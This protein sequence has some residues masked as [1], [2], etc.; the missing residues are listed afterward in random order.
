M[1]DQ[2]RDSKDS[3]PRQIVWTTV[4]CDGKIPNLEV[5]ALPDGLGVFCAVD[6]HLVHV[7]DAD[8]ADGQITRHQDSAALREQKVA[9]ATKANAETPKKSARD[10]AKSVRDIEKAHFEKHQVMFETEAGSTANLSG[11]ELRRTIADPEHKTVAANLPSL[12]ADRSQPTTA[13]TAKTNAKPA[14][15]TT[16]R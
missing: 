8:F 1:S 14:T 4:P 3:R 13:D 12:R 10:I 6:G 11:D 15:K 5:A 2:S 7:S 9:E 16:T